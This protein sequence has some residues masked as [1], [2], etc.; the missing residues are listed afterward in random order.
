MKHL[1]DTEA[2]WAALMDSTNLRLDAT[3]A[4]IASLCE[5]AAAHRFK[6]VMVYPTSVGPCARL[7]AGTGVL[8]GTVAGFPSGRFSLRAKAEEV[9]A[10]ADAGAAEVDVVMDHAAL[11]AGHSEVVAAEVAELVRVAHGAGV[12]LKVIA[13]T[14]ALTVDAQLEALRLCEAAG[15][16]FIKTSTGFGSGGAKA[17]VIARWAAA[18]RTGI[19]LKASGGIKTLADAQAMVAAGASRLGTSS[20][21]AILAEWRGAAP[22]AAAGGY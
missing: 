13:E 18:R 10:A 3:E 21:A 5:E 15:A 16:D 19:G 9:R 14:S 8:T 17:E 11:S 12:R 2:A 6:A 4:Q 22:A 20:A 1:P 7:L